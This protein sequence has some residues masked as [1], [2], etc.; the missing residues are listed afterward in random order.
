MVTPLTLGHASAE[1]TER[2]ASRWPNH[3]RSQQCGLSLSVLGH[4]LR[5]DAWGTRKEDDLVHALRSSLAHGINVIETS[6]VASGRRAEILVGRGLAAAIEVGDVPRDEVV[7]I[8]KVGF[9]SI[10]HEMFTSPSEVSD[11]LHSKWIDTGVTSPEEWVEGQCFSSEFIEASIHASRLALGLATIDVVLID[12]P[13]HMVISGRP[14]SALRHRMRQVAVCMEQLVDKGLIVHWGASTWDGFRQPSVADLHHPLD[15]FI[16]AAESTSNSGRSVSHHFSW[17]SAPFNLGMSEA[18]MRPIDSGANLS[19]EVQKHGLGWLV[20]A[21]LMHGHLT[22]RLPLDVLEFL[23]SDH[24]AA[25]ASLHFAVS[26]PGGTLAIVGM[27]SPDHV[28]ENILVLCEE[29]LPQQNLI[30]AVEKSS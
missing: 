18:L 23:G 10:D 4:G 24:S 15:W 1:G 16:S 6:P 17:V 19:H 25:I 8:T 27:G 28:S 5:V 21:P 13:E 14:P 30:A 26:V 7:V 2:H 29:P 3:A 22:E 12:M 11:Y 20:T 9:P